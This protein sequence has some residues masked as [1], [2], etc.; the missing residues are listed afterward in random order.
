MNLLASTRVF[1]KKVSKL[2]FDFSLFDVLFVD[3]WYKL[4]LLDK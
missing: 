4:L 2:I 1:R 3:V